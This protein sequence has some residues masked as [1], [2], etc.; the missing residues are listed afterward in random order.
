L[1][2]CPSGEELKILNANPN[3]LDDGLL[4]AMAIEAE[5][6][7]QRDDENAA[8]RLRN[9]VTLLTTTRYN[10]SSI[11]SME[12]DANRLYTQGNQ[13]FQISQF[14]EA[15]Q[16]WQQALKIYQEIGNP[17]GEADSLN[18]LGMAYGSI[19]QLNLAIEYFQQSLAI[20]QEIGDRQGVINYLNNLGNA[21]YDLGHYQL[22]IDYLQESLAIAKDIGDRQGQ[23]NSLGN[24]GNN[25]DSLGQYHLAIDYIQ[26]CLAIYREIGERQGESNSLS[27]LGNAYNSLGQYQIALEY[28]QQS[29]AIAREIGNRQG[30]A[31][32][33]DRLGR[34]H[35]SLGQYQ[36]AIE[37]HQQSLNLARDIGDRQ[38]ESDAISSLAIAYYYLGLYQ[39]GIEYDKQSLAIRRE[40]ADIYG[41][42]DSLNNL[43]NAYGFLRQYEQAIDYYQQS[44]AIKRKIGDRAGESNS[45]GGL[46]NASY[47]L[48]QYQQAIE[49]FQQ[50]LA[51]KKEIGNRRG[52]ANSLGGLGVAYQ[53]LG[54]Y[55]QALEYHRQSLDIS[56]VIGDQYGVGAALNNLGN[57]LRKSG[58]LTEAESAFGEA[59]DVWKLLRNRLEDNYKVSIIETQTNTY[60]LLQEVLVAQNKTNE[61]LVIAEK[62]RARAFVELLARRLSPKSVEE[63]QVN[64]LQEAFP[65]LTLDE[66]QRIAQNQNSTI[67]EYS[68][69][70]DD[71]DK[72][73]AL[74]IW[75]IK[76]TGEINFSAVDINPL[77]EKNSSLSDLVIQAREPLGI[78]ERLRN[79][80]P[81]TSLGVPLPIRRISEP[82]RQLHQYLIQPIADFLPTDSNAP[83]IF[84]PQGNLFLLPFPALQDTNGKFLIEQH[85]ILT[86]PSI[87]VLELTHQQRE[88]VG[89]R[90]W[91]V[92]EKFP[93]ALVVGNPIMPTIPLTE[94]PQSLDPLP[95]AEAEAIAIASILNT[96]A[97][98]GN[99]ATKEYIE[100]LM[101]EARLIHLATHG[102]LDDIRQLGVPGAI[103]LAPCHGDI[104]FLTSGEIL[105]MKLNASLVVLS[106]CSSGQGKITGDGVIGLSR[107]LF[108]AGVTSVIVSLWKV[109]DD[110]TQF[111]MTEF[112]QNLQSGMN[113]AQALRQAMLTTMKKKQYSRPKSWAAFTIIGEAA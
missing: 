1:L 12:A 9:L 71:L 29:L 93:H 106:A 5:M 13:Q 45:L 36:Q 17:S 21:Y 32:S 68:I 31:Y 89:S 40:I 92:A 24:I 38:S 77:K 22:A 25:Y 52:E 111:L 47:Y 113:K 112:Y 90:E 59:I 7:A 10:S 3:L 75:V 82:L 66:I 101:P 78:K 23:A 96:Q 104:G 37:Y 2:A 57:T 64:L 39:R 53:S 15:L 100:E 95:G 86:A 46:G 18:S 14:S 26:Q 110:S 79:A 20:G 4:R 76:P 8:N 65:E 98:I 73:L 49:Y 54:Q 41:E 19:G 30:Q 67:V 16:Y 97:I 43:G 91:K 62:G 94:P 81:V 58:K 44:L 108:A 35:R 105:Q 70:N 34:V 107:S 72:E 87:Q 84:I 109:G 63:S 6:L 28:H 60:R 55:Q 103:A 102:L 80:T 48:G 50:S 61:A 74:Y 83:V 69:I 51:L 11:T 33:L 42:A 56:R 99:K 27:N 88:A 85:T